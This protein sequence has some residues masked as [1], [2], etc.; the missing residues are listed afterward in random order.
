MHHSNLLHPFLSE[1]KSCIGKPYGYGTTGPESF[2]CS[3]LLLFAAEKIGIPDFPRVSSEQALNGKEISRE[4]LVPG[5]IIFFDFDDPPK[6][7]H[8]V[9]VY[10][11]EG[12]MINA[13]SQ[14]PP[15][16]C[17]AS[18]DSGYWKNRILFF[19]RI[20]ETSEE[21]SSTTEGLVAANIET[22]EVETKEEPSS[23]KKDDDS[24]KEKP[25]EVFM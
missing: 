12:K 6:E 5:D 18:I 22:R 15:E 11:G 17:E 23:N 14:S 19:R 3:G 13:Q 9:G 8:H 1:I 10:I 25:K 20:F 4:E 2:D 21:K 24:S 16:V 7:V